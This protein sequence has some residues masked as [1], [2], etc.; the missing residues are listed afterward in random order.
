V[1]IP[2]IRDALYNP[3]LKENTNVKNARHQKRCQKETGQ[4]AE[5]KTQRKT[6]EKKGVK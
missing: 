2:E 5:G 3:L 1:R 4:I 6:G